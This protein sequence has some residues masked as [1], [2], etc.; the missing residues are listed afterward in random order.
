M[1]DNVTTPE[2][3]PD[4]GQEKRDY[5]ETASATTSPDNPKSGKAAYVIVAIALVALVFLSSS[6][7]SCASQVIGYAIMSQE[8]Y[9]YG[10]GDELDDFGD[11]GDGLDGLGN[12]LEDY[13]DSYGYDSGSSSSSS[14]MM[15]SSEAL[16]FAL[17]VYTFDLDSEVS[18]TAYSG[19]DSEVTSW[20]RDFLKA[21]KS[22]NEEVAS[23]L[24]AAARD[25]SSQSDNLQAAVSKCR[26][27]RETLEAKELPD[28][29]DD[30]AGVGSLLSKA[31]DMALD[32]WD[33]LAEEIEYLDTDE[34]V[35]SGKVLDMD[36]DV[37]DLTLES[38]SYFESALETSASD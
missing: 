33:A 12:D 13:G 30:S 15:S 9:G 5:I 16:N 3:A 35:D 22:A 1:S 28:L 34:E 4:Q 2:S 25:S 19:A 26:D 36:A 29:G 38:A 24:N 18:A 10:L 11:I 37:E 21:D 17:Y 7:T 32:R 23:L 31:K 6:I 20:T 8:D 14:S 27:A